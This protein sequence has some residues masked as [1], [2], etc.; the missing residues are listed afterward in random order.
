[1]VV[2]GWLRFFLFP[3][4][5]NTGVLDGHGHGHRGWRREVTCLGEHLNWMV[6]WLEEGKG[7]GRE[8][9]RSGSACMHSKSLEGLFA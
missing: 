9:R 7:R 8:R 3:A 4:R 1:M 6:R 2:D 5:R